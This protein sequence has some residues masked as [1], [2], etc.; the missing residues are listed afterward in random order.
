MR[1]QAIPAAARLR[2]RKREPHLSSTAADEKA[3]SLLSKFQALLERPED[4]PK[5]K[6][7]QIE[8]TGEPYI[9]RTC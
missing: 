3:L 6:E 4:S 8:S 2:V 9:H 7:K 1:L 5:R